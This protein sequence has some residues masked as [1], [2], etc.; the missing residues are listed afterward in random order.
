MIRHTAATYASTERP[1]SSSS[2]PAKAAAASARDKR[3]FHGACVALAEVPLLGLL[4]MPFDTRVAWPDRLPFLN[5][6]YSFAKKSPTVETLRR[7][8]DTLGLLS[9]LVIASVI[10]LVSAIDYDELH[11][12]DGRLAA[13]PYACEARVEPS[14][15]MANWA[16]LA[17]SLSFVI[18]LAIGLLLVHVATSDLGAR[19]RRRRQGAPDRGD[20]DPDIDAEVEEDGA[21]ISRECFR[22]IGPA[23]LLCTVLF[24]ASVVFAGFALTAFYSLKFPDYVIEARGT[25]D[26]ELGGWSSTRGVRN[27]FSSILAPSFIFVLW[28]FVSQSAY[29]SA[30]LS[31]V[32]AKP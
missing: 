4:F 10:T 18:I 17:L 24:L 26:P 30:R 9:A 5:V 1:S 15:E 7:L 11:E 16:S 29:M 8:L 25:C 23:V 28:A 12:A 19:G 13:P 27:F 31:A 32:I 2:S 6:L 14:T 21:R 20:I 22:F 3:S